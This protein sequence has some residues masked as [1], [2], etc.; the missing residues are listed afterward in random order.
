MLIPVLENALPSPALPQGLYTGHAQKILSPWDFSGGPVTKTSH[1]SAR[2]LGT[3]PDQGTRSQI[4]QLRVCMPHLKILHASIK[5]PC[6]QINRNN[7]FLR[8]EKPFSPGTHNSTLSSPSG[9]CLNVTLF[10]GPTLTDIQNCSI[11]PV[12]HDPLSHFLS[13]P[14]PHPCVIHSTVR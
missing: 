7:Y 5:T 6:N 2:V 11:C 10:G 1:L 13:L 4:P 8:K 3:I 12:F 14:S 9:L